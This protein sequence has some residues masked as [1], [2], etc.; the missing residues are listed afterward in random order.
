MFAKCVPKMTV[1]GYLLLNPPTSSIRIKDITLIYNIAA[2]GPISFEDKRKCFSSR[3]RQYGRHVWGNISC[4]KNFW[5]KYISLLAVG[6]S[7]IVQYYNTDF[8]T[9]KSSWSKSKLFT[10]NKGIDLDCKQASVLCACNVIYCVANITNND[11][12]CA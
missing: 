10:T 3:D 4:Q 2:A 7:R 12:F 8:L 11:L 9:R 6:C 1:F 5:S